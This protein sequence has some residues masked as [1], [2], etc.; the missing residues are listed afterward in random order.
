M[1]MVG[2]NWLK[3]LSL[4]QPLNMTAPTALFNEAV[5]SLIQ[6]PYQ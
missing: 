5:D 6:S 4:H 2:Y 3:V 1:N